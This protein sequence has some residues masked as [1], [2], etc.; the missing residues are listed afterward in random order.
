[1]TRIPPPPPLSSDAE[2][3]KREVFHLRR[4]PLSGRGEPMVWLMGAGLGLCVLLIVGLLGVILVNG[5]ATFWPRPIERITLTEGTQLFG[6]EVARESYQPDERVLAEIDATRQNG[7]LPDG[8]V[9]SSGKPI[10]VKYRVGNRELDQA[11]YE[12]IPIYT[13]AS[14]EK[15]K[16]AVLLER[17]TWGVWIGTPDA[18]VVQRERPLEPGETLE[19]LGTVGTTT[20]EG[21]QRKVTRSTRAHGNETLLIERVYL[22]EGPDET[23]AAM[24]SML[25]E[26]I[27]RRKQLFSIEKNDLGRIY[28]NQR[29]QQDRIDSAHHHY[30]VYLEAKDKGTTWPI[31][32]WVAALVGLGLC[33]TGAFRVGKLLPRLRGINLGFGRVART[34][35]WLAAIM[36]LVVSHGEAPWRNKGISEAQR[37]RIIA[38]AHTRTQKLAAQADTVNE[39]IADLRAEDAKYRFITSD[40]RSGRIAPVRATE[41]DEPMVLSQVYR[42]VTTNR[43]ST[44]GKLGVFVSRWREFLTG[45]PR[46]VNS[47]GGVYPVIFGTVLLT[48]LLCV[49]VVP[50]GVVAAVYLREYAKQGIVTSV[51]RIA[52]NNLAGVPSIVYGVFGLGFFCYT[53]GAYVDR[54]PS[55]PSSVSRWLGL[56]LIAWIVVVGALVIGVFAKPQPGQPES[57]ITRTLKVPMVVCWIGAVAMVG[58]LL[59]S[60]PY[61]NGFYASRP[62]TDSVYRGPGILWAALTLAL[63]TLPVVIVATEEAIAAVPRTIRESSFGCGA[64]K[65]QTIRF[66]VLPSAAPGI[67]TGAILAMARGAGEVAPLMLV[68]VLKSAKELPLDGTF[69]YVHLERSFMHLGFHIFDLSFQS[70]DSEASRPLVWTTTLLLIV[71]VLALNIVA[72]VIRNRLRKRFATGHF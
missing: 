45:D 3:A 26:A 52:V 54:G 20:Y 61:F 28:A 23:L 32:R 11:T 16:D 1:M 48:L 60:T 70:A 63:L 2:P 40:L 44:F 8:S 56:L 4:T 57:T 58:A 22:S 5:L 18:I 33:V 15:A 35:L 38:R 62:L 12:W 55:E 59:S 7:T 72:I 39:H 25:P 68:G 53:L 6:I 10:R 43:E 34:S 69:P 19:S 29:A 64:S 27:E 24:E 51:I 66:I 36:L 41:F 9:N 13:I 17:D 37:D 14:K 71:I 46:D 67:L 31:V 47:A 49:S 30:N 42:S 50:L 65:W 21:H